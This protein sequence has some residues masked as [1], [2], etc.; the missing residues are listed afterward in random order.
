MVGREKAQASGG[1]GLLAQVG[2]GPSQGERR[3]WGQGGGLW[4]EKAQIGVW[5][6]GHDYGVGD[7]KG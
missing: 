2:S 4:E 1:G 6:V 7:W 5:L 3:K